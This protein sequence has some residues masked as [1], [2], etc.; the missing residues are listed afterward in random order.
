M[1]PTHRIGATRSAVAVAIV[2]VTGC[3]IAGAL[4][5]A[6]PE[7]GRGAFW[8]A[9]SAVAVVIVAGCVIAGALAFVV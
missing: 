6:V 4:T 7:V 1:V 5:V 3:V 2:I 8:C 9:L